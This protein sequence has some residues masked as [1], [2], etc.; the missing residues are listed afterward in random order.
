MKLSILKNL[1]FLP[2]EKK[3]KKP[4][5][6]VGSDY[7]PPWWYDDWEYKD[8]ITPNSAHCTYPDTRTQSPAPA[9]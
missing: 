5:V 7:I 3:H 4:E 2:R 8:D 9:E 1:R 6:Y